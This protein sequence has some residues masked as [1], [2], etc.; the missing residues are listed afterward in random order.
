VGVATVVA[1]LFHIFAPQRAFFGQKD[2]AQI[3]VLRQMVRDLDFELELVVCPIVRE[4]GGLALSSRNQYLSPEERRK[5]SVLSRAL[6]AGVRAF[7][8]GAN[9]LEL[10]NAAACGLTEEPSVRLDY[11]VL[12][13]PKT[14]LP[15]ERAEAG[16][17]LAIAAIVG[18]TRLIDNRIL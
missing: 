5:A 17:L 3:A 18:S 10:L 12:V 13:D 16:A 4:P 11:L 8:S 7:Q 1:K 14:L 15:V 6:D 2:A 9:S